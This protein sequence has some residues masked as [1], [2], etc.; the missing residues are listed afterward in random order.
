V[1]VTDSFHALMPDGVWRALWRQS[2]TE[3]TDGGKDEDAEELAAD[4]QVAEIM[5]TLKG[6]GLDA[7]QDLF[8]SA[9]R[10]GSATQK[11][12]R[13]SEREFAAFLRSHTRR[14]LGPPVIVPEDTR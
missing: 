14:L 13:D 11:A 1:T 9:L 4:P 8:K 10:F 6:L 12:M 7:N 2:I 5:N 3:G